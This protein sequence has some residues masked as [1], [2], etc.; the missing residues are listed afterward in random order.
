[1]AGKTRKEQIEALLVDAPDDPEL[2]YFLGM[3]TVSAGQDEEAATIFTELL[4]VGPD[5]VP[6]YLQAGQVLTRLGREEEARAV[7]RRGIAQ[8]EAKGDSHAA[9]EMTGFLD[10]IS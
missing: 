6:A 4:K 3:E 7:Y 8:A 10:L 1:M 5:Y 9:G 2:R